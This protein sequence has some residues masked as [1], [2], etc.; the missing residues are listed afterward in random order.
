M[1]KYVK[2]LMIREF[3]KRLEG[4]EEALLVNVVGLSANQ[5]VT[6]RRQL[7]EKRI[8]LLVIRNGLARRATAGTPLSAALREREGNLAFVWGGEDFISLTKE[9]VRLHDSAEFPQFE[10]RGGVMDGEPLSADRVRQISKWPSREEQ[11]SLLS[12]QILS[13]GAGISAAMLGPGAALASQVKKKS[14]EDSPAGS[15]DAETA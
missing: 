6:L 7:R 15:P 5:A 13:P 9:I 8:E 12:G 1:S 11:L 14:E 3:S 4:I 2:E 10:A